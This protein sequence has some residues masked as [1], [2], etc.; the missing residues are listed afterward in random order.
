MRAVIHQLNKCLNGEPLISVSQYPMDFG[1]NVTVPFE[2]SILSMFKQILIGLQML[3]ADVVFCVEHDVLY[4][5]SHFEFTPT[6]DD[7]FYFN[8]NVWTVNADTGE[9]LHYD[10]MKKT[11]CLVADRELLTEHYLRKVETVEKDGWSRRIGFEPGK[12]RG[13]F[14]YFHSRCPN[15]DIKHGGNLVRWRG[16]LEQYRCRERLKDSWTLTGSIP[17][18]G[19][20]QGR[21]DD[22]LRGIYYDG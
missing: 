11:S 21:F 22:F 20:I 18:W 7:V 12:V 17:H 15:V 3:E 16:K 14:E 1:P 2:R 6:R 19:E 13:N 9:C 4:H 8:R 5:P 10:G